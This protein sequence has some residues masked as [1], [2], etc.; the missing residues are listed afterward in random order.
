MT[1]ETIQ[2]TKRKRKQGEDKISDDRM[3]SD[4]GSEVW[5]AM[6]QP[7]LVLGRAG[8]RQDIQNRADY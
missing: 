6:V 1:H 7:M 4:R 2:M 5:R 8:L 3:D